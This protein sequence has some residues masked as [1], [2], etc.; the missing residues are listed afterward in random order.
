MKTSI[1][2]IKTLKRKLTLKGSVEVNTALSTKRRRRDKLCIIADIVEIAR[3]GALKT[4]IMYKAN[5]SFTQ[6][7]NYIAFLLSNN[8]IAPAMYDGRE[9]YMVTAEGLAFLQK[10]SELLQ[11]LKTSGGIKKMAAPPKSVLKKT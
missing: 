10:H 7:N 3:E 5:L 4:Q 8:L 6:L 1:L 11:M 9:G 2:K